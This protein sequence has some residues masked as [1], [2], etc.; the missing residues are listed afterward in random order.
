[1]CWNWSCVRFNLIWICWAINQLI[2]LQNCATFCEKKLNKFFVNCIAA[3]HQPLCWFWRNTK[4][5]D[6]HFFIFCY[7]YD[8]LEVVVPTGSG[9][10]D[11]FFCPFLDISSHFCN[12]FRDWNEPLIESNQRKLIGR[13]IDDKNNRRL[14]FAFYY[15]F[16]FWFES[17]RVAEYLQVTQCN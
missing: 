10:K 2:F 11:T 15:Q 17:S 16:S 4:D 14:Y 3:K 9:I 12:F 8:F 5:Q 6:R 1:M 7:L 13:L